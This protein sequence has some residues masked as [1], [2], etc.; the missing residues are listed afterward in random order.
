M[1]RFWV[2]IES[3]LLLKMMY[4]GR[5]NMGFGDLKIWINIFAVS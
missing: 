5:N 3:Y 4:E 1:L 2:I